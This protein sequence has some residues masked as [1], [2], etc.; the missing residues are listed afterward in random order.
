MDRHRK[1][2]ERSNVFFRMTKDCVWVWEV[3]GFVEIN[4]PAAAA[5]DRKGDRRFFVFVF[6]M[7]II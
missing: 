5:V 4:S 7:W 6:E 2:G 1:R 3:E